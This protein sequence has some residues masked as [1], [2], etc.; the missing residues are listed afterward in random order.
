LG[1]LPP[2]KQD[3]SRYSESEGKM[4]SEHIIVKYELAT[5]IE[6]PRRSIDLLLAEMTSGIRYVS[7][8]DGVKMDPVSESVPF[9]DSSV[10]GEV[11]SVEHLHEGSFIVSYSLPAANLDISFG[12]I[13]NLWPIVAGEVFNLHFIKNS[14][15]LE[16]ELPPSYENHYMGPAFGIKRMRSLLKREKGPVFGTIIKPNVGLTPE[17]TAGVAALLANAGFD[18][19]K[20]DEISVSPALCPLRERVRRVAETLDEVSQRKGKK[21]LFAANIT[22]DFATLGKAAR[23][24]LK[25]GAGA[26][27][28][29]PFCT[30]LSS[31]DFLRRNFDAPI[32]VHRVGYGLS[33]LGQTYSISYAVFIKLFRLL[34][35]DFSHVGGIWGKS[36]ASIRKTKQYLD[37]LRKNK[38]VP[39]TWPVVTGISLDNMHDYYKFY[40]DDT[41][42][43]DHI[44]IYKDA[45]SSKKKL[46]DLK[47]RCKH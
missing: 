22:S 3:A 38:S 27:M 15:L 28:I 39:E 14:R 20:D 25:A 43:L 33:C 2:A 37:I 41:M 30:G 23:T 47:K 42:F 29:D 44:D 34:G 17:K 1:L 36:E 11:L 26:L 8:R 16:L 6:T 7:T 24:A 13:T 18:F 40:G 12:G 4:A 9:V 46:M 19:I 21:M 32:Y 10:K 31:I 35:A 5:Q 45:A